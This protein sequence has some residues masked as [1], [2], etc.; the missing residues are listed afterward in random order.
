M[1]KR[2]HILLMASIFLLLSA[3]ESLGEASDR[4][5]DKKMRLANATPEGR[6]LSDALYLF[7]DIVEEETDG[8]IDVE[9]YTNSQV[10]GDREVFEGMQINTIQGAT[11]STGPISQFAPR[12]DVLDLPFLFP[13]EE[14]AYEVL[15]GPIGEDLLADLPDQNVIGLNYWENGYRTLS[16]DIREIETLEDVQG[17][18]LRTLE[19]Q[20]H[21]RLWQQLGANPTPINYGELYLSMDQGTVD[22]Q[23]NPVGNVVNDNFY[24]VQQYITRTDHIY[25]ASPLMLSKPFWDSLTTEEQEIISEAADKVRDYQRQLNR[26]ETEDSYQYL[27]EQGMTVTELSEEEQE[28]FHEAVEPIYESYEQSENGDLMKRILKEVESVDN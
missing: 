18:D 6:S 24:E 19:S 14:S 21:I 23:E 10:G 16:N 20:M 8:E 9:V 3:C 17:L 11:I 28:R 13:D 5:D 26:E 4:E 2:T 25:N 1:R 22:G 27:E 15:D 12:F 7:G